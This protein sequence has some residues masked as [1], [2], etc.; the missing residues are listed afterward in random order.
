MRK[1][2]VSSDEGFV[3]PSL[4]KKFAEDAGVSFPC[5]YILLISEHDYLYPKEKAFNFINKYNEHDE[6]DISFLGYKKILGYEDIYSY[7]CI[8]DEYGYGNKII[9]FGIAANGDYI[10]FDYRKSDENPSVILMYQDDFYEDENGDTKMSI[11]HIADN[12]ESFLEI[13]YESSD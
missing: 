5:S 1:L 3:S 12:F 2:S 10:C 11:S 4:I 7:S 8:D 13:L 6:S 9:A